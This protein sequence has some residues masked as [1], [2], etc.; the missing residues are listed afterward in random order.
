MVTM[1][2]NGLAVPASSNYVENGRAYHGYRRGI[3]MYP[4]DEPEKDRMDIYHKLFLVARRDQL[5]Q[6]P[7]PPNWEPRILDLGCGT[8]IWAIDMADR[9]LN[10]EVLGLDLVNIQ[11]EKIPPNL[12]FR[13]P[14][15]YESPWSLGEDSWDLIHLRM[16]CGSVSSWPELYQKIYTHLRPGSGWI[17][18]VE[19]DLEPRCDDHTLSPD[20]ALV[21]WYNY[22]ADATARVSRPIGYN[23]Q[24]RQ[25]LQAAGFID[26][27]EIVI[28]APYSSWPNDPHQKEIGRWYN[29]GITE[30][31]EALSI[32]AFTRVNRWDPHEHVKPLIDAVRAQICNKKIHAYNNM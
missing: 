30:G 16:A 9:Y 31:L 24:T 5:H 11:P 19:I 8:G 13:V 7:I 20:S 12:R 2:S 6:A 15:D 26:I 1:A 18:H 23:H 10:A 25:M 3:Y 4:C 27:Q 21:K 17:E 29:L 32:A 14:R 22:L 28:R